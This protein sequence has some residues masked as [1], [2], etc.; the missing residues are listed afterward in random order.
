MAVTA[1]AGFPQ[2]S[3]I[4]VPEIWSGKMLV[5]F[6]ETTVLSQIC[7][8]DYEG[9]I[10]NQGDKVI[11]RSLP[12]ID[13]TDYEKGQEITYQLPQEGTTELVIDKGKLWAFRS[14]VVDEHQ[15]DLPFTE[16][17][18]VHAA[19]KTK[20]STERSEFQ[21]IYAEAHASN[22]GNTAGAISASIKLGATG[23]TANHVGLTSGASGTGNKRNILDFIVDCGVVLD[24]QNVPR[25]EGS[26]WLIL[27]MFA[28]GMLKTS[29]L[30]DASITGDGTS[31]LRNG[32]HGMVDQFEIFGSNLLYS[33]TD[34]GYTVTY[35]LFGH[36]SAMSWAAQFTKTEALK[37]EKF[38]GMLN[39]GL[40]IYGRETLKPEALGRAIVRRTIAADT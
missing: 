12:D 35:A 9:E 11:I 10:K 27:P 13:V 7:N 8:T 21:L 17:R 32:R 22:L 30:K 15:A 39:R 5:E 38:F 26:R 20:I 2:Q 6:Y 18:V 14:D 4:L 19:K 33:A 31:P 37:S 16:N 34:T 29:D 40:T 1:A 3:G 24:E 36:T 28:C 25:D 23:A